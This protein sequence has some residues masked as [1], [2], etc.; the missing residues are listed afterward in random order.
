MILWRKKPT[1]VLL[2]PVQ[3]TFGLCVALLGYEMTGIVSPLAFPDNTVVAVGLLTALISLTSAL[4]QVPFLYISKSSFGKA[5]VMIIGLLAFAALATLIL[6]LSKEE[7]TH[8]FP[9][10][11]SYVLQGVGRACY[12][13][14]NK[15]LYADFFPQDSEAAFANIVLAGGTASAV[16]F[17][18]SQ[19]RSS[20]GCGARV[21]RVGVGVDRARCVCGS[22]G[23]AQGGEA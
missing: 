8:Y 15:A 20:R 19:S 13:G 12:E 23:D 5:P 18:S 10:I 9:L 2:A 14:T 3:I 4:L 6:R 21:G 22:G 1:V 11:L 17:L 16:A 7:L